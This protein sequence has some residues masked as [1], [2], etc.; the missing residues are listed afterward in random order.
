MVHKKIKLKNSF[1]FN[2]NN[3]ELSRVSQHE[4][5]RAGAE[6]DMASTGGRP[7]AG[8]KSYEKIIPSGCSLRYGQYCWTDERKG[9][10][11]C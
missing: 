3:F 10:I 9:L 1:I 8:T 2:K 5:L 6:W 4:K 11:Y 7:T